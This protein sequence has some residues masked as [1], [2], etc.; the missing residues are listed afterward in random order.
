M[1][2]TRAYEAMLSYFKL[3]KKDDILDVFYKD[4]V[5]SKV[6]GFAKV[7]A[8]LA[9]TGD[10]FSLAAVE[11]AGSQ[12][13]CMVRT[14]SPRLLSGNS[15]N[16]IRI[17]CVGSVWSSFHLFKDAFVKA[18]TAPNNSVSGKSQ[19]SAFE[20]VQL[21][22]TSAL[23]AAWEAARRADLVANKND[24][25]LTIDHDKLVKVLYVHS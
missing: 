17:V 1:D 7:L 11:N 15:T 20:L 10:L 21:T 2:V 3:S 23:G 9:D 18:A 24:S 14:L 4:F 12:L 22:E 25:S 16:T 5:K 13:G 8:E 19:L 6:A